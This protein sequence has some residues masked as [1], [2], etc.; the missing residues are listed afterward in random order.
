MHR[1]QGRGRC[2]EYEIAAA[3]DQI[4][5][6]QLR[7]SHKSAGGTPGLSTGM[8]ADG[9]ATVCM[10]Y[11]GA[12]CLELLNSKEELEGYL[13]SITDEGEWVVNYTL[14]FQKYMAQ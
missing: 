4:L 1:E 8:D 3:V 6:D 11:G 9:Y 2:G 5:F 7:A 10:V 13:V 12:K 14:G